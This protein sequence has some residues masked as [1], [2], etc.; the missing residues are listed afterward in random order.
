VKKTTSTTPTIDYQAALASGSH[1][2]TFFA[3]NTAGTV[4]S[5]VR[6]ATVP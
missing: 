6:Y 4:W 5:A 3:V 2:F 1:R